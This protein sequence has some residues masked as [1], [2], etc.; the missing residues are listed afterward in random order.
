VRARDA[1][2][3]TD[4]SPAIRTWTVQ[5]SDTTAPD[6]TITSGPPA[7]TPSTGATFTFTSTESGSSFQCSLDQAGFVPCSP[8]V[9]YTVSPGSHEFR[10][11]ARDAAGNLDVSP[12]SY[13]WTVEAPPPG[14]CTTGGSVTVGASADTWILQSS[15]TSNYR[16]DSVIKVDTKAGSNAR[17]LVRFTLPSIP[18]GCGIV[19]AELR[20]YAGSYKTGRTIEA[21]GL[22]STW[23]EASVTWSNQPAPVGAAAAVASGSGYLEWSVTSQVVSMVTAN[24]GF[25]IRDSSENG[26]GVEQGFHSREK[27]T[28]NPPQLVVT[29]G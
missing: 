17:V 19:D 6:T 25:L 29:F 15:P 23:S 28:D 10:V 12:A 1:A 11:Q 24:N 26:D 7:T 27:G 4:Q 21:V 18:A 16:D 8:P 13:S 5:A 9:S 14:S 22:A 20:L 3:N 2:G